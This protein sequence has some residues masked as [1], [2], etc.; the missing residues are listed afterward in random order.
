MTPPTLI[1]VAL[2]AFAFAWG[3]AW[4]SFLNVVIWRLPRG[5]SLV[6][7]PSACPVCGNRIRAYDNV[8]ILGWLWLRGKCRDCK[9]PIS[10][11]YPAVEL[12]VGL[13]SLALWWHVADGRIV[14]DEF[15]VLDTTLLAGVGVQF[16]AHFYFVA[17]L[18]AVAFI[19]LDL[20]II[21]HR[22]TF[23]L[24]AWG[25]AMAL[26]THK[27]GVWL[28]YFPSV[29]IV[30]ALI[31]AAVGGGS[32]AIVFKGYAALKGFEGGGDGDIWLLAA[33]GANLG[34]SAIPIVL[35]F[36]SA[37]GILVALAAVMFERKSG[38]PGEGQGLLIKGAHT[39][40]Y[41]DQREAEFQAEI[42]GIPHRAPGERASGTDE[43]SEDALEPSQAVGGA[44]EAST[45]APEDASSGAGTAGDDASDSFMRL[46]VPFGPFLALGAIEFLFVGRP[47][48]LWLT[49]GAFP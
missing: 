23:P 25:L 39:D 21:P 33:I 29:D 2:A 34:W 48:L 41:W 10:V 3:A 24:I 18:V 26:L 37:Q 31:G 42:A 36:A 20:T 8:P 13:L 5:M 49:A 14:V 16:I 28:F 7:P 47:L 44:N 1:L 43:Q 22:L 11:R 17:V 45:E 12:L 27:D 46:A 40:E 32:I 38:A 19:D 4:G 9:T 30:D 35:L 15:G 6:H